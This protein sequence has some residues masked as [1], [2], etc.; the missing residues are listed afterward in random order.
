MQ[1]L[2]FSFVDMMLKGLGEGDKLAQALIG[3]GKGIGGLALLVVLIYYLIA[4]LDGGKF[5]L[6]MLWPL[7]VFMIVCNF[8]W[9]STPVESFLTQITR[10]ISEATT[11]EV[12]GLY[13][14][15]SSMY[16]KYMNEYEHQISS[17][18]KSI[19]AWLGRTFGLNSAPDSGQD[20][21]VDGGDGADAQKKNIVGDMFDSMLGTLQKWLTQRKA[22]WLS[23]IAFDTS[24]IY[25]SFKFSV[26]GI[27]AAVLDFFCSC[28]I[29]VYMALGASLIAILIAFGPVTFAFAVLPGM[30]RN[31]TSWFIRL[32]QFSL[33]SPIVNLIRYFFA[34]LFV[35]MLTCEAGKSGLFLVGMT[36]GQ[37]IALASVPTIASMIVEGA[38]GG[39]SLSEGIR[40]IVNP[41]QALG[42]YIAG[43]MSKRATEKFNREEAERDRQELQELREINNKL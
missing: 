4:L 27:L 31:M 36:I 18:A 5:Q 26:I 30:Q 7:C 22:D 35:Q 12:N 6:K 33:W 14:P 42:G 16:G 24:E 3:L 38:T 40:K 39:I 34:Y 41:V 43:S 23:S 20:A 29:F 2:E 37:L 28:F 1:V 13:A 17:D 25:N 10:T 21:G 15:A 11:K 8:T 9:V 32:V 19:E